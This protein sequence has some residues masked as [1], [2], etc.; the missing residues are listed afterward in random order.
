MDPFARLSKTSSSNSYSFINQAPT[1]RVLS[2]YRNVME[3]P[4][5]RHQILDDLVLFPLL[6][7]TVTSELFDCSL[8]LCLLFLQI[9]DLA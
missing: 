5:L 3:P 4:Y 6:V 9:L 1:C 2:L 8:Q 7:G